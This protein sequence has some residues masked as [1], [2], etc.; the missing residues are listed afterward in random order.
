MRRTFPIP[1]LVLCGLAVGACLLPSSVLA[2]TAPSVAVM[3]AQNESGSRDSGA[4][5]V[6]AV[7]SFGQIFTESVGDFRAL[8][9][10]RNLSI[11]GI[12]LGLAGAVAP[13]DQSS[14]TSLSSADWAEDTFG[15]AAL[16]GAF[17]VQ[18]AAGF[19]AYGIGRATGHSRA[20]Q[21]GA[22]IVRAQFLSQGAAQ[23]IKFAVGRT[24]PDGSPRSFPSGHSA[25]MFATATVLQKDFGWR[26]GIPAYAAATYVAAGRIQTKRHYLSDVAFGAAIGMMAGHTVTVG[27]GKAR[28]AVA[29]AAMAGGA[30]VSL[31]LLH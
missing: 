9:T 3:P 11:L 22:D 10:A 17:P 30:G 1:T 25:S 26:V 21:V 2:Q 27:H 24:R 7:P 5:A 14:S 28:F 15:A 31:T 13:A 20:A 29:P 12:G 19:A 18:V 6:L 23:A 8:P 4:A 16:T